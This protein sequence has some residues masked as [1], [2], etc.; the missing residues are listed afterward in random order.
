MD[1]SETYKHSGPCAWSP[2]GKMLATAVEFRLVVRDTD[3]LQ[4]GAAFAFL[5]KL[6]SLPTQGGSRHNV[7]SSYLMC[8]S[9][10]NCK[11]TRDILPNA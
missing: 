9:E 11:Q 3:S 5:F 2:D 10:G 1:F 7:F 8:N 6:L 4:V